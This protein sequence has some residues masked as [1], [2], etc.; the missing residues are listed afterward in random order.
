VVDRVA[1][2]AADAHHLDHRFLRL[3]IHDLEHFFPPPV[4]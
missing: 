2:A 3:R 1:A 4:S